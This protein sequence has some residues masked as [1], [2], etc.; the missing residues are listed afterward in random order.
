[1]AAVLS[2]PIH[3]QT[4]SFKTKKK[5]GKMKSTLLI[6]SVLLAVVFIIPLPAIAEN[7]DPDNDGSQYAYGENVGWINW[8]PNTGDGVHVYSDHLDGYIWGEN[9]G[10]INTW[11]QIGGT[12]PDT[13]VVND[14]SGNLSG[15]AWGEN[16]GW[17]NFAPTYGGVSIDAE[18]NIE[19]WAWGENIGW[20]HLQ[21]SV[22]CSI[23]KVT[24]SQMKLTWDSTRG[25][26][27]DCYGSTDLVS[28]SLEQASIASAGDTTTWTDSFASGNKKFYRIQQ[29]SPPGYGVKTS[30]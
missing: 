21:V 17:I 23:E 29:M 1:V 15:Y 27:Y 20:I 16:V 13:G 9:I 5:D 24:M 11:Y 25:G 12:G 10:W 14:G 3:G 26:I 6:L 8:E 30:W 18:G 7:I 2:A 4:F 22:D 28:W 19:G